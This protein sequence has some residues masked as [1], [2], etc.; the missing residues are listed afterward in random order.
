MRLSDRSVKLVFTPDDWHRTPAWILYRALPLLDVA[1]R[2]GYDRDE[3]LG[4]PFVFAAI[5]D[6]TSDLNV[7]EDGFMHDLQVSP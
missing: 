4:V 1:R 6:T 2:M 7:G 5:P 3:E